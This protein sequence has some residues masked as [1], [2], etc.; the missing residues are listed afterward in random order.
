MYPSDQPNPLKVISEYAEPQA[1]EEMKLVANDFVYLRILYRD[2]WAMV[3]DETGER[4]IVP[5][6]CL[7]IPE[8]AGGLASVTLPYHVG[9]RKESATQ[10]AI[11]SVF[12]PRATTSA[13]PAPA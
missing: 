6:T 10:S 12:S 13:L 11:A 1:D 7:D 9:R 5:I 3:E 8:P 2:G 4:G